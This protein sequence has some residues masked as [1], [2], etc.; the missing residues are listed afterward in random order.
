MNF[1]IAL[2]SVLVLLL[3]V[4]AFAQDD[5]PGEVIAD[6]LLNPRQMS[7]D[8]DGNL[9]VAEAGIAG[10]QLTDTDAAYG[11]TSRV[12]MIT[13]DGDVS[14]VISGL[15]SYREGGSLGAHAVQA[16]GDSYWLV[17]GET[18]D[19]TLPFTHGLLEV[20]IE[21]GRV[22]T[23]VDLLTLELEA[24][25]DGN[26]DGASNPTDFE[27]LEDG[28]VLIVNAGCNC[29]MSWSAE[30][31]LDVAV[32]WA[33]EDEETVK[34]PTDVEIGPDGDIYVGFL[35]GFPW[36]AEGARVERWSGGELVEV[37][38]GLTAVTGLEVTSDGTIY[39]V[40][41]GL[42]DGGGGPGRVVEVSAD[43]IMPVAEGLPA[44]YGI[45]EAADGSL[46]VSVNS[47]GGPDGM[48]LAISME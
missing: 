21:S 19:P 18:S 10:D 4:P 40:E 9:L 23:F 16:V 29:L 14:T 37:F 13:P 6:G 15:V 11:A 1:R 3:A 28:T 41:H 35:S 38:G 5:M 12:S 39:A 20:D 33:F 45:V 34:V 7:F 27:V 46:Y 36:P 30:A 25:P 17:L 22:Q 32:V 26:P 31:G 48:I 44:P 42:V 24:D 2:F 47:T 8:A 43:G